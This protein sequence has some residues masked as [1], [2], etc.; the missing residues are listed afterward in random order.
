MQ[1]LQM[2]TEPRHE[3]VPDMLVDKRLPD[4]SYEDYRERREASDKFINDYLQG[5]PVDANAKP[6]TRLLTRLKKGKRTLSGLK[7]AERQYI[8]VYNGVRDKALKLFY[9]VHNWNWNVLPPNRA[10]EPTVSG[11]TVGGIKWLNQK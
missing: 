7:Q 4:E 11:N 9:A 2:S 3:R 5:I 10:V 8:R 6:S 1:K